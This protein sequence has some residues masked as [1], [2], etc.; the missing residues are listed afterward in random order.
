MGFFSYLCIVKQLYYG[1]NNQNH[2]QG[3]GR[4]HKSNHYPSGNHV[5]NSSSTNLYLR[6]DEHCNTIL[7]ELIR[8]R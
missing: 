8:D 6:H 4:Y 5:G 3:N 7:H 1:K 2:R